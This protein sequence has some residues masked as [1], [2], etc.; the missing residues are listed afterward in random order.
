MAA[1]AKLQREWEADC[2]Q[3][4]PG[5]KSNAGSKAECGPTNLKSFMKQGRNR[6]SLS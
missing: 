3:R 2:K 6:A 4:H 5:N 1:S